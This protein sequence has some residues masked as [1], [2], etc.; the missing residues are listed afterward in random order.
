M[1]NWRGV[2]LSSSRFGDW[3]DHGIDLIHPP[4][5]WWAWAVGLGASGMPLGD[6]G[7]ALGVIVAGYILQRAEEGF[8]LARFG[9]EMHIWQPFDSVFRQITARRNPNLVIL[10]GATLVGA[11]REGLILV[12]F[13]VAL[14]LLIHLVRII[15]AIAASRQGPI[16]SWMQEG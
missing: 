11:P 2:T 5:W 8:F 13:W 16:T 6:G 12:A 15:Q 14:C 7:L 3:L 10:T 4:F 1:A 9:I